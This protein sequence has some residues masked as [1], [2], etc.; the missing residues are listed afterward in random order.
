VLGDKNELPSNTS[1]AQ[2]KELIDDQQNGNQT[3]NIIS[4]DSQSIGQPAKT[5]E[6]TTNEKPKVKTDE[7]VIVKSAE[8]KKVYIRKPIIT[9]LVLRRR[10]AKQNLEAKMRQEF[11]I[12]LDIVAKNGNGSHPEILEMRRLIANFCASYK[13]K[14]AVEQFRSMMLYKLNVLKSRFPQIKNA[15]GQFQH[16]VDLYCR[17]LSNMSRP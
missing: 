15:I 1:A 9:K 14:V 7:S 2:P 8:K 5:I 4:D 10:F 6:E 12:L 16:N 13:T 17:E 3:T 11:S